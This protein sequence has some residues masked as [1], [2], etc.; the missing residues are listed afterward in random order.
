[1]KK[2]VPVLLMVALLINV[3]GCI[4]EDQLAKTQQ[5]TQTHEEEV[6]REEEVKQEDTPPQ[7]KPEDSPK[8]VLYLA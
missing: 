6:T 1:M 7:E 4:S 8:K 3:V 5:E 2:I